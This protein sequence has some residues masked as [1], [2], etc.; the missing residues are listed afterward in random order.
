MIGG[1]APISTSLGDPALAVA[2]DVAGDLA[3]AGRVADVDG[4][5]QVEMLDDRRGVGG[6][7]V[8]VVAVATWLERPWPRR[9][10]GDDAIA[11]LQEEEHLGVPVVGAQRPAVMEHDRLALAPV[12]VEDLGAVFGGDVGHR[13]PLP[14][15][16]AG[17][18]DRRCHLGLC[19]RPSSVDQFHL[20]LPTC[21]ALVTAGKCRLPPKAAWCI[22]QD[23]SASKWS[24][25]TSSL[26]CAEV[27]CAGAV[28]WAVMVSRGRNR[29]SASAYQ[30]PPTLAALDEPRLGRIR[31]TRFKPRFLYSADAGGAAF[32]TT[33]VAAIANSRQ[34]LGGA[35]AA[36]RTGHVQGEVCAAAICTVKAPPRPAKERRC[37]KG[38]GRPA[39]SAAWR[40]IY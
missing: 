27:R 34:K 39:A 21:P 23:F 13:D 8:H 1:T 36:V 11:L 25:E 10:M 6:V 12:L 9:S 28:P 29:C 32:G 33:V 2:G 3:A 31:S 30:E 17:R 16:F 5:A 4:V 38:Q 7:V 14:P 24:N 18:Q 35:T 22:S 19:V 37:I 15:E 20:N 26:A 40:E